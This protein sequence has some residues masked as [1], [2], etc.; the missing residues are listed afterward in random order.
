MVERKTY[1][2]I[3][4]TA[5]LPNLLEI[6]TKSYEAFLQPDIPPRLRKKQ[7]LHGVIHEPVSGQ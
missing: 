2:R 7:G 1:S 3:R 4:R 6:Q 5:E